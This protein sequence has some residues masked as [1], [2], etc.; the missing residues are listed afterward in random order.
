MK[1]HPSTSA[2]PNAAL[3][4]LSGTCALL[5]GL[6]ATAQE[7]TRFRGPNGQGI[8]E[9]KT[10]PVK[11]TEADYLWKIALPGTGHSSP[12]IWGSTLFVT[13]ADRE[14]ACGHLLAIS[15]ADGS[16]LWNKE[17]GLEEYRMNKLNDYA[18]ATPVVDA[19]HVYAL[20]GGTEKTRVVAY[21]HDGTGAWSRDFGGTHCPHGP[22]TSL[23]IHEDLLVFTQEHEQD[24]HPGDGTWLA[25]DRHTGQTKWERPRTTGRKTSYSTPCVR[26]SPSGRPEMLFTSLSHGITGVDPSSGKILWEAGAVF[27]ARVVS[28]PVIA[29]DLVLGTCGKRLV[30]VR[31]GD[32]AQAPEAYRVED[33]K[34]PYVPT[35][36]VKDGL[37]F[38]FHDRGEV[39][40]LRIDTGELLWREKPAG[41]YYGSPVWVNGA[42]YCITTD[43]E[44]VVVKAAS[45]YELLAVNPLGEESQATPAVAAGRMF[46]RTRGHLICIGGR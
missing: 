19:D 14:N 3:V 16:V 28:S 36:L 22:G 34:T 25:L 42:V 31:P 24:F 1:S 27:E 32:S 20:W 37:L 4:L 29:G 41:K 35:P 18:A 9:A 6:P 13:C 38:G 40:C 8:S 12:V 11:W 17:V 21:R 7:W 44:V 15:V 33:R 2:L 23:M 46:L 5:L 10:I 30:A 43:G 45:A 26:T 39:S